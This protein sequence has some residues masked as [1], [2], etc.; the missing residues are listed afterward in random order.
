MAVNDADQHYVSLAQSIAT[1][2]HAGQVDKAGNPYITHPA[3]VAA[4][5]QG[6]KAKAVAWLHDVVE[7]TS[8]TFADLEAAG[9]DDE[10][11]AA[12]RLL[13]HDKNVPYMDY[14]AKVKTNELA[15]TVKL[16]DLAHN[17]DLSR[18]P[19]VTDEDLKRVQKYQQ[20]ITLLGE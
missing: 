16:A 2:A 12:L 9:F 18:L 15:R 5:V 8:V 3:T 17:S 10:I 7:D 20:A 14:V 19:E 1:K 4:S 6:S 11:L 13:T